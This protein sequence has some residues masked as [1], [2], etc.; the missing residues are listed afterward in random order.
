MTRIWYCTNCGY[1]VTSRGR[2]HAC[3]ERLTASALPQLEGGTEDDE[4]GYRL[5]S[6][7]DGDRARLIQELNDLEILHRFE[8][9]ELVVPAE[10]EERV[11][12]LVAFVPLPG[13]ERSAALGAAAEKLE[14]G[15]AERS[16]AAG[17]AIADP[18]AMADV[19]LLADAAGRLYRDPTDMLAD[20]DVAEASTS[21]FMSDHFDSIGSDTWAAVGRV[22]RRL[23][24]YLGADE[25]LEDEIRTEAG[26]LARLLEPIVGA[27]SATPD[28]PPPDDEPPPVELEPDEP[29]PVEL[30][31]EEPPPVE[32]EPDDQ[33][34]ADQEPAGIDETVYELAEWLPEQR[35]HLGLLLEGEGISYE[36]EGDELVVP[37]GVD[38]EVE[39]LFEKVGGVDTDDEDDETRYQAVAELSR[40]AVAS[41]RIPGT[42]NGPPRWWSGPA[43][44]RGRRFSGW[45]RSI[46][47]GS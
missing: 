40:P 23:L 16:P 28:E 19:V 34:P 39:A 45:T 25:A 21:V 2:C 6:W 18:S 14:G 15:D 41:R 1:E 36:W 5:E 22:T 7:N 11:D 9:D 13:Q 12:D 24:A 26:I 3:R 38:A 42:S 29:P 8:G 43:R 32:L 33:E 30:E 37:A 35:A 20:S 10:D 17:R 27:S 31:P 47:S 46:G 4:V 44:R